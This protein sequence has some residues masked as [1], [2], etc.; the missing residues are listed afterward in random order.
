MIFVEER[1]LPVLERQQEELNKNCLSSKRKTRN[2]RH[3]K[4]E[5]KVVE[6]LQLEEGLQKHR[7]NHQKLKT[8]GE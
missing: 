8:K 6:V 2:S 5:V 3:K 1:K 7:G 4:R